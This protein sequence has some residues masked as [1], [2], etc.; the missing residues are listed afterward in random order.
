[1]IYSMSRLHICQLPQIHLVLMNDLFELVD[2]VRDYSTNDEAFLNT[3]AD[4]FPTNQIILLDYEGDATET[5]GRQLWDWVNNRSTAISLRKEALDILKAR[6]P[7][8]KFGFYDTPWRSSSG[9]N[10][11]TGL[12]TQADEEA[13]YTGLTQYVDYLF[14]NSYY[15]WY[16]ASVTQW[17]NEFDLKRQ[18]AALYH[19]NTPAIH[20]MAHSLDEGTAN[21]DILTASEFETILQL[22]LGKGADVAYWINSSNYDYVPWAIK[23][24]LYRN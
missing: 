14:P 19:N 20:M 10:P 16:I 18:S 6:R 9:A 21:E 1:M 22:A 13:T 3:V 11:T 12:S 15:W 23:E 5:N 17:E 7:D 24:V 4:G 8:L 2:G